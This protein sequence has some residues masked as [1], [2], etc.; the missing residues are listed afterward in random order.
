MGKKRPKVAYVVFQGRVPGIYD[1][2]T[3]CEAQVNGHSG[4][5]FQ[6]YHT[7]EEAVA[8]WRD[9]QEE[10]ARGTKRTLEETID[11]TTNSSAS[12]DQTEK[13]QRTVANI[14]DPSSKDAEAPRPVESG[15]QDPPLMADPE[16]IEDEG[17]G[18]QLT[19]EQKAVVDLALVGHNIF[20]TGAAGSGKTVTLKEIIRKLQARHKSHESK[21]LPNV[22]IVAPTGIAAL[23][24]NGRTTYSFAGWKPDSL[25]KPMKELLQR[26]RAT[27]VEAVK[28]LKVLIIEEVSMVESQFL[29]RLNRLFQH[30]LFSNLPFGG[31]QVIFVGDF[32]QLPPVKPFQFCMECGE[33]MSNRGW[34]YSCKAEIPAYQH[35]CQKAKFDVGDKW[36]FK[37]Q[38]WADLKLRH[39]KLEQIHRQKDTNFQDVL[40]KIRNGLPL[41]DHE[42]EELERTKE[43][44]PNTFAVRLM[45]RINMVNQFNEIELAKLSTEERSWTAFDTCVKK[46]YEDSDKFPPRS[47]AIAAKIKEFKDG[48]KDHSFQTELTLKIGAKVVLLH[49]LNPKL[50]LVN[51]SQGEVVKFSDAEG[52]K[53]KEISQWKSMRAKD[54]TGR[55]GYFVPVV[56]FSNGRCHSI[57]PIIHDAT[58]V[59]GKDRY[60]VSRSQIPLTLGWAL[61]IHKSQGM[62]LQYAEVSSRDIFEPG[63]LYVGVSR[64]ST[65]EGLVV[66][67]FQ[68]QMLGLDEEVT[69]FYNETTWEKLDV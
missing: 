23:P 37:A 9:F 29:E 35:A 13:K 66:T 64:V 57:P 5:V 17:E 62:S 41:E 46:S 36:A 4:S 49:N 61:S 56:K 68:R 14:D 15:S 2:W 27:T 47:T 39:V 6:G 22:H 28:R 38:V 69:R 50:G 63:Q 34:K 54:F 19:A 30:I 59:D 1:D 55:N 40:N 20:L 65:L 43:L 8:D 45:S 26:I 32:H 31:K 51:G 67:G 16:M 18:V 44:P 3:Q 11:L 58:K 33:P 42:W 10:E 48:L 24:L 60:L 21:G 53:T 52:W 25:Q 12:A 7:R